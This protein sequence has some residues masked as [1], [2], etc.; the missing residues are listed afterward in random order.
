MLLLLRVR[1]AI[2]S[3]VVLSTTVGDYPRL[4]SPENEGK[5]L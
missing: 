4:E 5:Y 1:L 2:I 3:M